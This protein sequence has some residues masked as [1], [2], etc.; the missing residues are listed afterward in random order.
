MGSLPTFDFLAHAGARRTRSGS[1]TQPSGITVRLRNQA[2]VDPQ[3][4]ALAQQEMT[5]IYKPAGVELAWMDCSRTANPAGLNPACH[6]A[7]AP[8][9]V[10]ITV[11]E[12]SARGSSNAL[13]RA[14]CPGREIPAAY[15][16]VFFDRVRQMASDRREMAVVLGYA[17]AHE[18]GHLLLGAAS[19]SAAG[20]M[21]PNW[22]DKDI[23]TGLRARFSFSK[24]QC[25]S[26]RAAVLNRTHWTIA[27]SSP[28]YL[29]SP[30][31]GVSR[32]AESSST[33]AAKYAAPAA[34]NA[35]P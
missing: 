5:R 28:L 22:T 8:T 13:G 1:A 21:R 35:G 23:L 19:H 17:M 4:L 33:I 30:A 32:P 20:I 25:A 16:T 15:A 27:R 18:L 2:Q 26:L 29:A 9:E 12:G 24:A 7:P 31:I 34:A 10:L 3:V 6:H 14:I 11:V